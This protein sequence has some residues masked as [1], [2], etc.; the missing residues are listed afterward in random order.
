MK[1]TLYIN[2]DGTLLVD[3]PH[4]DHFLEAS[5]ASNARQF[6]TWATTHFD[7]RWLTERPAAHTFHLAERLGLPGHEVPYASFS[8]A[9]SSAI[10]PNSRFFWIDTRLTPTDVAWLT[11]HGVADRFMSVMNPAGITDEHQ[12]VL[13]RQAGI[14]RPK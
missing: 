3:G 13:A 14:R 2:P 9:K 6:M 1:P 12:D 10:Q 4:P 7:V 5:I 8:D 11:Q